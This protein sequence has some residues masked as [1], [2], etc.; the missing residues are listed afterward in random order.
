MKIILAT[1]MLVCFSVNAQY[2]DG[3]ITKEENHR[4]GMECMFRGQVVGNIVEGARSGVDKG[5]LLSMITSELPQKD[6]YVERVR[7]WVK[8]VIDSIYKNPR[9]VTANPNE[10]ETIFSNECMKN[11][12]EVTGRNAFYRQTK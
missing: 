4:I 6:F 3:G 7:P 9:S 2:L 10:E 11:P 8:V 1:L 5:V 12:S